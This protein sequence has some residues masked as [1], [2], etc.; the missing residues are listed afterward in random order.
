[1]HAGKIQHSVVYSYLHFA[2]DIALKDVKIKKNMRRAQL[3]HLHIPS[4][5]KSYQHN[6]QLEIKKKDRPK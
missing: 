6:Y 3:R 1:M 2:V 5:I 4:P